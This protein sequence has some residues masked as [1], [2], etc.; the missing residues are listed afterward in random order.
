M[1]RQ[2]QAMTN[3]AAESQGQRG[4]ILLRTLPDGSQQ[5]ERFNR[6]C[7]QMNRAERSASGLSHRFASSAT[8]FICVNLRLKNLASF[9]PAPGPETAN[10]ASP[11][12]T[13]GERYH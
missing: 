2:A 3:G 8:R 1:D 7:T 6:R 10:L 5:E 13:Y 12:P 11:K 9:P 4:L